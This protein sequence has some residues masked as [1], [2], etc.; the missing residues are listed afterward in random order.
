L[1]DF[2]KEN[3]KMYFSMPEPASN[4]YHVFGDDHRSLCGGFAILN[5]NK[6]AQ[7]KVQGT[8]TWSKGQDCKSCFRKAK[9]KIN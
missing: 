2:R 4:L 5:S 3:L 6:N 9:L 8:E 1:I 7:V